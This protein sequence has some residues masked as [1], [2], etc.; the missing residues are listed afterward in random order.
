MNVADAR[1]AEIIIVV[2]AV[3]AMTAFASD[4]R[5]RGHLKAYNS[6]TEVGNVIPET[7]AAIL[8]QA[9]HFELLSLNPTYQQIPAEGDFHG[10]RILGKAVIDDAETRKKLVFTFKRAVAENQGVAAACFDPR[11]GIR[12]TRNEKQVD[13]VICFE[14]NQV[15]VLGAVQG[16]FLITRSA[17]PLFDSVLHSKGAVKS[18]EGLEIIPSSSAPQVQAETSVSLPSDGL[19]PVKSVDGRWGYID[20]SQNYVIKPQFARAKRFS[21]GLAPAALDKKFGYI[22]ATGRFAIEPQFVFAEPFSE[23]LAL[24]FP[25]WGINLLGHAE[26]Y[27]LF[28]RAGYIDRTGKMVIKPRFVENARSFSEG[29]AA[30]QAG[31]NYTYGH[32]KWG[33]LDKRGNWAIQPQF[34]TA[35]DFSE[36][37]AA[38]SLRG[39]GRDRDQWGYIDK[40]G[41]F[42]IPVQFDRALPFAKG[43]AKVKTSNGWRYI[44]KQGNFVG[45]GFLPSPGPIAPEGGKAVP[46]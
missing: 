6:T 27:T 1:R 16:A 20:K 28:V 3:V 18:I 19:T 29:V 14:C 40:V 25:D 9:D 23:G 31:I 46:H 7:A 2:A 30:F 24:V 39:Q 42:V 32:S 21:D 44:D 41:K 35:A 15:H 22:E 43:L 5:A 34:D 11:H 10:Y 37:L 8:E 13:F 4:S 38:V 36:N 26:G 12:V 45:T 17:Q 33:Y